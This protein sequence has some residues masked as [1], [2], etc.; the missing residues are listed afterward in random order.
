MREP[1]LVQPSASC[2]AYNPRPVSNPPA[3]AHQHDDQ[4]NPPLR[5]LTRAMGSWR[6]VIALGLLVGLYLLAAYV[7]LGQ[8]YL[9]QHRLIDATQVQVLRWLGLHIAMMLLAACVLWATLRGLAWRVRN[10]GGF[11]AGLGASTLLIGLSISL[12]F[13]AAG[14]ILLTPSTPD[15]LALTTKYA[16][17]VDRV[18]VFQFANNPPTQISLDGLP[19]WNDDPPGESGSYNTLG[20][21]L[22]QDTALGEQLG[23]R[24]RVYV[25]GYLASGT[26]ATDPATGLT[27]ATPTRGDKR[28]NE[29]NLPLSALLALRI[30]SEDE[31]GTQ[32]STLVW[33]P[34]EPDGMDRLMPTRR[35]AVPGLGNLGLAFRPQAHDLA[36]A[37]AMTPGKASATLHLSETNPTTGGI[38][39]VVDSGPVHY[40]KGWDVTPIR[41]LPAM[42]RVTLT[43]RTHP[44]TELHGG[45]SLVSLGSHPGRIAINIGVITLFAGLVLWQLGRVISRV[46]DPLR[47]DQ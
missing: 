32:V 26:L 25:A 21:P 28:A 1:G 39:P 11:I 10:L 16:D 5:W 42:K 44:L 9:W 23:Y 12:R 41:K 13:G 34:F 7:P 14:L 2:I 24:A 40:D 45:L 43:P 46:K 18:L 31:A 37:L 35:Y 8:R 15:G 19:R 20:L 4:L 36:F 33:L 3:T 29:M 47:K 22:H 30:E 27:T 6:M 38:M 17:P